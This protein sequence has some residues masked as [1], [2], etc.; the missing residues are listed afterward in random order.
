MCT[1]AWVHPAHCIRHW[2]S[3]WRLRIIESCFRF[4]LSSHLNF[5]RLLLLSSWSPECLR[6]DYSSG[7][8]LH[9]KKHLE[10]Q[11]ISMFSCEM[12]FSHEQMGYV[13]FCEW[14]AVSRYQIS[15]FKP[16]L[17]LFQMKI[18]RTHFHCLIIKILTRGILTK[19]HLGMR[20]C[21][22]SLY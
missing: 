7:H 5:L 4:T 18:N 2:H 11:W 15:Y 10:Y 6:A 19:L 3:S 21:L 14:S 9:L 17:L 22:L 20:L 1:W 8:S 16:I 13:R 12:M